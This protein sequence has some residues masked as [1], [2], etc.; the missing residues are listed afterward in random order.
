[1][2]FAQA[3]DLSSFGSSICHI[4]LSTRLKLQNL[5]SEFLTLSIDSITPCVARLMEIQLNDLSLITLLRAA[6]IDSIDTLL[7]S[8]VSCYVFLVH[9]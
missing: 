8:V 9:R 6:V 4:S 7:V 1:M 3:A 5:S 2:L